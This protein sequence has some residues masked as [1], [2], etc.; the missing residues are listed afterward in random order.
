MNE[1]GYTVDKY[2]TMEKRR[3]CLTQAVKDQGLY[4]VIEH[5]DQLIFMNNYREDKKK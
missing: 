2:T 4:K 3:K 1:Y 5:L